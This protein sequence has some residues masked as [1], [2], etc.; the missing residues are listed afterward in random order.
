[1][2]PA[3]HVSPQAGSSPGLRPVEFGILGLFF[4]SGASALVYEVVWTRDLTNTF[5]GTAF[6]VATVLAAFMAGLALGS[7]L[8]GRSI[9]RRGNPLL[10]Y[11]LLE[12]GIAIWALLL[13]VLLGLL[14]HVY[15]GLHRSL[16]PGFYTLSLIRFV[17]CFL[18]LLVPTTMMGGTLP[19]LGK[20]LLR[21][22]KRL[23]QRAGLLYAANTL[24]AVLGTAAGGFVL[25]PAL[26]LAGSTY[27]AVAINLLVAVAAVAMARRFRGEAVAPAPEPKPTRETSRAANPRLLR[28]VLW[29]YAASGF[30]A[31]AYEV[32]WTKTLSMILGNTTYAFTSMLTTFLLGLSLGSLIFSRLADRHGRP[33]AL[34]A[35]IQTGIPLL[36][37]GTLPF[38][39]VLPQLF[40]DGF[41]RLE[42]SWFALELYRI[43][44]AGITMILPTILMGGTF[45]LVTRIYVGQGN[46]GTRLGRLYAANTVGAI[47]GSF[48]TGFVLIPW[49]GRQDSVLAASFVNIAAAVLLV[50]T[51]RWRGVPAGVRWAMTAVVVLLV[52][53]T[54]VGLRPWD[55]SIISSGA[56]VYAGRISED[57]T[58]AEYMSESKILFYEEST[59]ATVS[60][61]QTQFVRSLRTNGKIEASSHG[62]MVTQKLISHLPILYHA[63]TPRDAL[64][65]GLASGISVG[66]LLTHP[67]E[68]V[69]T[70][71]I[72]P[73]MERAARYFE[74]WNYRCLD[75]PRHRLIMNDGRNYL[76]LSDREYDIIV[77]EP[78][79]P[80]VAGV[81]SLFTQEFFEL[82]KARLAPGGVVCQWV[83]TYQFNEDDLKTVLGTFRDA[84]PYVHLWQ[85]GVGDLIIVSSLEPLVLDLDR[86]REAL[87]G[88]PGDDFA[89]LEI[90]P[91]E[92]ILSYFITDRAGIE[93]FVGGWEKRVTDDNLY[94]E[95]AVPRHMFASQEEFTVSALEPVLRSPSSILSG[96]GGKEMESMIE[97]YR[98][99]RF[100]GYDLK[101][102]SD[103]FQSLVQ[104]LAQA[105]EELVNRAQLSRDINE[106][107]I[108]FLV[109]G[110]PIQARPLFEEAARTGTREERA[111]ALNNLGAIVY[112]ESRFDSACA[113][114]EAA[115]QEEPYYPV[116]LTNLALC[117]AREGDNLAAADYL[118]EAV[119]MEPDNPELHNGVAYYLARENARLDEAE[120]HARKAVK[121]DPD[122]NYRDTLG[123][124]LVRLKRWEEAEKILTGVM[125]EKP[126]SLESLL[127]L[128]MARA[129]AGKKESARVDFDTVVRRAENQELVRRARAELEKL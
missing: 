25:L 88:R 54:V 15:T 93:I 8:F 90:L 108:Q 89:Q 75:D 82:T 4:L 86:V 24:G 100:N 97:V 118:E 39:E 16:E 19:V 38:M 113:L 31:L 65:I 37:L 10:I 5:G 106:G 80:W 64:M 47:L 129:G 123:L 59:E 78:P 34:L 1:M 112:Q 21:S 77:S 49:I 2:T 33:E 18:V 67:L 68:E 29:V 124:V 120:A 58:V 45:P 109:N 17:L 116:V 105:P 13:P 92:Q 36:A 66:A 69:E 122:A 26:G 70:V 99:V 117:R 72:I 83:Q 114:W 102:N 7:T 128:G 52:P 95:Y 48:L 53:A 32:A 14:D 51:I 35:L 115:I 73:S 101:G 127:H 96:S 119:S 85:G 107:G 104:N 126:G 27:L 91:V 42:G 11:G 20:L 43:L 55:P 74:H 6:A 71:E 125:A 22:P 9:D 98:R 87:D 46:T 3:K 44:L 62:D 28:V 23:G 56:Y 111:I 40:V 121:I 30:A 61:S 103:R 57:E 110:D 84:Y 41:A 94:L 12:A 81:G 60:V 76:L 63:G 50:A 79:N